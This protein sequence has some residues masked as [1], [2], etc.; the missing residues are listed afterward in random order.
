M[1]KIFNEIS[2][3]HVVWQRLK[4]NNSVHYQWGYCQQHSHWWEL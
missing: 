2:I 4:I 3:F 1:Q